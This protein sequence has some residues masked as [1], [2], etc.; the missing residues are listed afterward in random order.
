MNTL[1]PI[2]V[3]AILV[4]CLYMAVG[5]IRDLEKAKRNLREENSKQSN[6]LRLKGIEI[7]RYKKKFGRLEKE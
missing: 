4:F 1:I 6:A 2:I 5:K 7:D 3:I